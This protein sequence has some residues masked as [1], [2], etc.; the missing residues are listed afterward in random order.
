[1]GFLNSQ[2]PTVVRDAD[3]R[4][5]IDW[6]HGRPQFFEISSDLFEEMVAQINGET[7]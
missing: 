5:V 6:P 3:G 2:E 7:P 4:L 1:M